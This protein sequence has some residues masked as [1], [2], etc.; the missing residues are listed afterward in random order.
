MDRGRILDQGIKAFEHAAAVAVELIKGPSP[1]QH[2]K[3]TF[4]NTFQINA[5]REIKQAG[6][7]FIILAARAD[8]HFH[9]LGAD[10]FQRAQRVDQFLVHHVKGSQ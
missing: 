9:R 7:G 1:R 2:F 3:R 10:V 6:K 5:P 8:D 4:P